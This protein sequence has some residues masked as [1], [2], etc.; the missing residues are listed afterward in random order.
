MQLTAIISLVEK[1]HP[2]KNSVMWWHTQAVNITT[3]LKVK[4][5]FTL[6][7]L[8]ATNFITWKFHVDKYIKLS[9]NVILV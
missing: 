4:V 6:P 3:N 2:D 9:S 5:N 1:L 7:A 8:T